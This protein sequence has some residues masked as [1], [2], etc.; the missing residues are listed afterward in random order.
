MDR[1]QVIGLFEGCFEFLLLLDDDERVLHCRTFSGDGFGKKD[2]QFSGKKLEEVFP[3]SVAE[4]FSTVLENCRKGMKG[5]F[6]FE[7]S[8]ETSAMVLLRSTTT[9]TEEGNLHVFFGDMLG[10]P[11]HVSPWENLERAKELACIYSVAEWIEESASVTEF[12]EKLPSFLVKGMHY[13]DAAR[14]FS[15]FQNQTFGDEPTVDKYISTDIVYDDQHK[16]EIRIWYDD[17]NLDFLPDEQK[18]LNEIARMLNI[19]LERKELRDN[20]KLKE[21]E[22]AEYARKMEQLQKEIEKR[23]SELDQQEN[24][25]ET[26][27]N[28]LERVNR[29]WAE[30]KIRL[31]SMFKAI[32]DRVAIIDRDRNVVMTNRDDVEPGDKCYKTFF[33]HER[34]CQDCRLARVL[35]E[36]TPIRIEIRDDDGE[37][38]EVQ[39]IPIFNSEHEVEGIVEFYKNITLEKTYEQQLQQADKLASLG[40]L[41]SGIGHEINNPN[42]FIRGNIKIVKQ[43]FD[44]MLPI[45]DAEFEKN[46]DLKIARLKYPFFREHIMTLIDDMEHGSIRIKGI[47]EG[48]KRFARRDEGQ[49]IDTVDINT[50]I[51]ATKRLVHNQVHKNADIELELADDVPEFTGNAQKIEQVLVNLVINASQA[52]PDDRRG[53]IEVTS[54]TEGKDIVIEVKDNGKGMSERTLKRIFDPFYTTRRAR[55]GTGLGLPIAYRIVEEH[56]GSLS[57]SSKV[58][59]GTTFTIR[60][61]VTAN[62][63]AVNN[64]E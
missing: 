22:E 38:F 37:Y 35:R 28:Y 60:I 44:D 19:A 6:F 20:I 39:A 7:P 17:D 63:E 40:Q 2:S 59:V 64:D 32:P 61:P 23:S 41:V 58:G 31:E 33:D 43:A 53:K 36:K 51:H 13:P 55:G 1:Q 57:V 15:R 34:P 24:K 4:E 62:K 5:K 46:P 56:N 21:E 12:F 42:Q 18:M 27:N 29:D 50:L 9:R 54:R 11:E 47:V 48:L 45:V 14:V 49:L 16:G 30:S 3:E 8:G 52:M 25:L 26:V 10:V